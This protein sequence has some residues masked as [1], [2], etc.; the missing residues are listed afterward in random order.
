MMFQDGPID[1]GGLSI[2]EATEDG[3][4][5]T[6][7]IR[8]LGKQSDWGHGTDQIDARVESAAAAVF[9]PEDSAFSLYQV[10]SPLELRSVIAGLA[11]NRANPLQNIDVVAF[12]YAELMFAGIA[13]LS[14]VPGELGCVAANRLHVDIESDSR[15][16]YATLCRRAI[17]DG[18][19][20]R[21]FK[22]KSEVSHI[23]ASQ[24]AY[25]CEAFAG[26]EVC[27]CH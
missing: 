3:P 16:S 21:R 6:L 14:D 20:V 5:Q 27:P 7:Y 26:N 11:A 13:V 2:G 23:V 15:E 19:A 18:R 25:G 10:G 4:F 24:K 8:K 1:L 12:T 17:S 22:K 9:R